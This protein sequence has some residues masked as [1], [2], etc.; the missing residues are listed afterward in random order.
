MIQQEFKALTRDY[1]TALTFYNDLLK[2]RNESQM[3][4][5][6]ERRQQGE[7]FRVLDPPGL[8]E[9]PTFPDP[10]RFGLGGLVVG[11]ALGIAMATIFELQDK[12]IWTK[13]DVEFY[14]R[15]P[16]LA[17]IPSADLAAGKGKASRKGTAALE[18]IALRLRA[19][20]KTIDR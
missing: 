6:L 7:Q 18:H 20:R 17:L 10:R 8:P 3:A 16:T 2:K 19:A 13:E 1:Q 12:S 5:E 9:R 14:L 4:T 15:V 11:L